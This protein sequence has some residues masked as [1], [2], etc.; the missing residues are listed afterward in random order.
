M[1]GNPG[2]TQK[3]LRWKLFPFSPV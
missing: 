1:L 3:T 2:M